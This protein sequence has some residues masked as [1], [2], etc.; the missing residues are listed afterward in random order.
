MGGFLIYLL[1]TFIILPTTVILFILWIFTRKS[2]FI[3]SIFTF[4][5]LILISTIVISIAN[6]ISS[7]TI[8]D[9]DDYYGEYIINRDF[10]PGEQADW[11]Y[12]HFRFEIKENDSIYFYT[13][14]KDNILKINKGKIST[15]ETY[16][17]ARLILD[18]DKPTHHILTT[19]P[20]TYRN[21]WSFYLVFNSPKFSNMYF[22]KGTWEEID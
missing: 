15:T 16:K 12:N 14:N 10:F 19:N 3:K 17:S 20:T 22:K 11:Q 18:I 8:L 9:N 4:W 5:G 1:L 13:T 2:G 21:P 7:K 6:F